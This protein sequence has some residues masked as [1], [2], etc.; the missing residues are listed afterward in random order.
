VPYFAYSD[1]MFRTTVPVSGDAVA[2]LQELVRELAEWRLTE[3]LDR[4]KKQTSGAYTLKVSHASGQPILF[5]PSRDERWTPSSDRRTSES[6]ADPTFA[7]VDPFGWKGTHSGSS[8]RS[9]D[10]RVAKCSS[11]SCTRR[12]TAS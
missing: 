12:S 7:F 8:R 3:Y 9:S 11:T 10:T 2:G 5:L 6:L 1:R 4:A